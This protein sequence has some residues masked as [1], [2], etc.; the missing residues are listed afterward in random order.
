MSINDLFKILHNKEDIDSPSILP[1]IEGFY[2]H[3]ANDRD[4]E[5]IMEKMTRFHPSSVG[6]NPVCARKYSIIMNREHFGASLRLSDPHKTSLLRIFD[7]GHMIHEMYQDNVLAKSGSLYGKWYQ[8]DNEKVIVEGFYPGDGWRYKEPR[9]KWPDYRM[10]GYVDGIVV[11]EGKWYVL[12]IKSSNS[13]SFKYIK[14][15]SKEPRDYHM[16]QAMLYCIAPNDLEACGEIEGA[17]ILYVNKETGEELDF[18]VKKDINKVSKILSDI[19]ESIS[20]AEKKELP[21]R[22]DVCKTIKSKCAKECVARD[23]CFS[24]DIV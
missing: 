5:Y 3:R 12:E 15:V 20:A 8:K 17:I 1:T 24:G 23:F 14:S 6:Y 22:L 19:E 10:S 9:M 7:H 16:K 2:T 4:Y 18:F 13:N 11:I 21:S